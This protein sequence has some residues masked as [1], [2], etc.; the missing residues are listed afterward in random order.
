VR[1]NR[2]EGQDRRSVDLTL[3]AAG[4]KLVVQLAK[5][6]DENDQAFFYTLS[7]RQRE[8]FLTIIKQLLAANGWDVR[9]HGRDRME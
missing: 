8:G 1:S 7:A 6:A 9:T 3:T 4:K 2:T 5:I